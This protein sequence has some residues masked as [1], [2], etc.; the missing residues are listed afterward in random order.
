MP[1]EG[2]KDREAWAVC[3]SRRIVKAGEYVGLF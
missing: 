1:L 2:S 3:V